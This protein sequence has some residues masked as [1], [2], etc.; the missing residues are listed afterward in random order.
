MKK[1]VNEKEDYEKLLTPAILWIHK[2]EGNKSVY[3]IGIGWW[4]FAF[5]FAIGIN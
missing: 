3:C 5:T 1:L 2:K 4:H